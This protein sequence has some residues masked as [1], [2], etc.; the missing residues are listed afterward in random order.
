MSRSVFISYSSV[1]ICFSVVI[2]VRFWRKHSCVSYRLY[3][4]FNYRICAVPSPFFNS[5][6]VAAAVA[7]FRPL[8]DHSTVRSMQIYL[9]IIIYFITKQKSIY[10]LSPGRRFTD[11]PQSKRFAYSN[12]TPT[13]NYTI[14]CQRVNACVDTL[15]I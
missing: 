10:F 1:L 12:Y 5:F 14:T 6:L 7:F 3:W 15:L 9:F 8:S 4:V 13:Y 2:N 11:A